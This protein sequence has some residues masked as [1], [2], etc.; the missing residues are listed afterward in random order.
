MVRV[1]RLAFSSFTFSPADAAI[2]ADADADADA[3]KA[4]EEEIVAR[5][6]GFNVRVTAGVA[7]AGAGAEVTEGVVAVDTAAAGVGA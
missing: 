3:S 6:E 4:A 2:D 7:A 5:E 1:R